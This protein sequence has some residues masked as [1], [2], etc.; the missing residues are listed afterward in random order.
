MDGIPYPL[1][2]IHSSST[3]PNQIT[4]ST[5][6][7]RS[8]TTLGWWNLPSCHLRRITLPAPFTACFLPPS[9][10]FRRL[11]PWLFV[12]PAGPLLCCCCCPYHLPHT[13]PPPGITSGG[14]L[15]PPLSWICWARVVPP[16]SRLP[17]LRRVLHSNLPPAPPYVASPNTFRGGIG[18]WDP[19]H[20]LPGSPETW[21]F[22]RRNT[23]CVG[24]GI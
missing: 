12:S 17:P 22:P 5:Y 9:T 20:I 19:Q 16:E 11:T 1:F 21:T 4:P 3:P 13:L 23:P 10:V 14:P 18:P 8:G 2:F 15:L 24:P 7:M 6:Q